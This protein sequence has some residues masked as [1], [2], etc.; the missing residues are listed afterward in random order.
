M[1]RRDHLESLTKARDPVAAIAEL[2]WNGLDADAGKIDVS[3]IWND[4]GGLHSIVVQDNGH[5]LPYSD[6]LVAFESLGGSLKRQKD[7]SPSGRK[8]HGQL[9]K[10]RFRAFAL[11]SRVVW[12]TCYQENGERFAYRITG[13]RENLGTFEFSEAAATTATLGTTVTIENV[14]RNFHLLEPDNTLPA[15]ARIFALYLRRYSRV[16]ISYDGR[17]V[18]PK[19]VE[20]LSTD[21]ELRGVEVGPGRRV[22]ATLTV[23]EWKMPTERGV[24]LCDTD[25]FPHGET[26]AGIRASGFNFTAY[27]RSD[28]IAEL[29]DNDTLILGDLHEG[30]QKLVR[31]ARD[32]LKAHFRKRASEAAA[33][34]VETWKQDDVYPYPAEPV[35]AVQ[36]VERQVFD[37]LAVSV[38]SYL[39]DFDETTVENKRFAFGLI[40]Q[41]IETNPKSLRFIIEKV[42][43]LPKDRQDDF[44]RLLERT[45]LEAVIA[46]SRLV[47]DRL[48]FLAGLEQ[49]VMD[50]DLKK[51][52]RERSQ[53]HRLVAAQTW[54]F[55]EE[56][57]MTGDDEDLT[58]ILRRIL[59]AEKKDVDLLDTSEPVKRADGR[60]A[61][62]DLMLSKLIPLPRDDERRHLVVELKRPKVKID[63]EAVSQVK[64]YAEAI[65]NDPRF[66]GTK[67]EWSFWAI[68]T[69]MSDSVQSEANQEGRPSGLLLQPKGKPYTVWVKSWGEIIHEN[70]ARLNF[71][72]KQLQYKA[73]AVSGMAFLRETYKKYIPTLGDD[74]DA[75]E[76]NRT[77]LD[78]L[79]VDATDT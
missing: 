27:L 28:Y 79:D 53:L 60:R 73:S 30:L 59:K 12:D 40:K 24:Y 54:I 62:V 61:I 8:Q 50:P 34:L 20:Q 71:I 55:G 17:L 35:N 29:A 75:I 2:I 70:Q 66:K 51:K 3:L 33:A 58:T 78:G 56:F 23:I 68:S 72:R 18:D 36:N 65:A 46:T 45:S 49:L 43:K 76:E 63:D 22:S 14:E 42:F 64:S 44:A 9:G 74:T 77:A 32:K 26:E 7:K 37:I 4:L 48:E 6:G 67:T 13:K 31:V 69:E 19:E 11:G 47:A 5:G 52:T 57:N 39:P 15:L 21:Y 41:A 1:V 10:G 25:G 16:R 38:H